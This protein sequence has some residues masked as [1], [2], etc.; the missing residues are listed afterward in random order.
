MTHEV[1]PVGWCVIRAI[2]VHLAPL[3]AEEFVYVFRI[4]EFASWFVRVIEC[5][6]RYFVVVG[7]EPK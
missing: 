5:S 2:V 3:I 4:C 6:E 1:V 7:E